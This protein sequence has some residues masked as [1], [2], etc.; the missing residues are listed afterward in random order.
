[1]GTKEIILYYTAYPFLCAP[2]EATNC[3]LQGKSLYSKGC[4]RAEATTKL[5]I[6]VGS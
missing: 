3:N 4:F 5:K 1:M 6:Q 2:P